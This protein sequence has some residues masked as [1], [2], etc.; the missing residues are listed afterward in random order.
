MIEN[1]KNP[2]PDQSSPAAA[3][4]RRSG[5]ITLGRIVALTA[6]AGLLVGVVVGPIVGGHAAVAADTSTTPTEHTVTVSGS[7]LVSVAPDVADISLGVTVQKSTVAEAQSAAA[8]LM[9][10]V[11]ASVKKNGVD[12]RDIVTSDISLSPVYDYTNSS[13][14]RLVGQQFSNT[15][16]ITVRNLKSLAVVV[17]DSIAAGATT[18]N[19]IS[20]RLDDPKPVQAQA[21]QLAM[22]DALAK[23]NA[24]TAAAGVS[25]RG[26]ATIT[27]T[28]TQPTPVY[29][30]G[31]MDA[32]KA[33]SS[34]P[35]QT[36]TTDIDVEVTVSYI[37]G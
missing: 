34:T 15:I 19:G 9:T 26:V 17:D 2:T 29:Y 13:S 24:L 12:A 1:V 35:I 36:G 5:P 16:K 21:R 32:A 30:S 28:A 3:R 6:A 22:A 31:A 18:I 33:A 7:G 37:I 8:S 10:A 23:A 27:E 14:P 20:F 4:G 25:V 11:I